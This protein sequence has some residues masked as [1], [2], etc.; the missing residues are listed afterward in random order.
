MP[1]FGRLLV[2]AIIALSAS[3]QSAPVGADTGYGILPIEG[4]LVPAPG[5][6]LGGVLPA[7]S[8]DGDL[9][10]APSANE[11][12]E[13]D[14]SLDLD[15]RDL[16]GDED[17]ED[18]DEDEDDLEARD[19]NDEDDI[20]LDEEDAD[21][22]GSLERR[23]AKKTKAAPKP[24]T[25]KAAVPKTAEAKTTKVKTT[26]KAT[27]R[28]PAKT[29]KVKTTVKP[30][31]TAKIT[32]RPAKTKTSKTSKTTKATGTAA[33]SA[34]SI[35]KPAKKP[36]AFTSRAYDYVA[37]LFERDNEEFVGWHGTNSD[38]AAFWAAKGHIEKPVKADGFLD[39][40]G[41]GSGSSTAGTS[42]ADAEIGPGLYVADNT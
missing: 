42:G 14:I 4:G 12:D 6:N 19:F 22:E 25:T 15:E 39:F 8:D 13:Q 30:P 11:L 34:C 9:V 23:A 17:L 29:T 3:V 28:K 1:S 20:D 33:P 2:L 37:H 40:L 36:R 16:D 31:K 21:E 24:K 5:V 32:T 7:P 26:A 38:T 41:I 10:P 27:P 18:E 35:K